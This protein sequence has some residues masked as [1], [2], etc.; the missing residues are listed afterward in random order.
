MK[1]FCL[2]SSQTKTVENN[3]DILQENID[4]IWHELDKIPYKVEN[5]KLVQISVDRREDVDVAEAFIELVIELSAIGLS[6]DYLFSLLIRPL[7]D[8]RGPILVNLVWGD[9]GAS[10]QYL[11][12][13]SSESHVPKYKRATMLL[14]SL[15]EKLYLRPDQV[16]ILLRQSDKD[17]ASLVWVYP[18]LLTLVVFNGQCLCDW[19]GNDRVSALLDLQEP[20]RYNDASGLRTAA[21]R[22]TRSFSEW[23]WLGHALSVVR[24][25]EW[26]NT[27]SGAG[28][29][30][31]AIRK[32]LQ[33]KNEFYTIGFETSYFFDNYFINSEGMFAND[34]SAYRDIGNT[35]MELG[36]SETDIFSFACEVV[37]VFSYFENTEV[38]VR[39]LETSFGLDI[40]RSALR[41]NGNSDQ[42]ALFET[43]FSNGRGI[44]RLS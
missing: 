20:Y 29:S 33:S 40:A 21:R 22:L 5:K 14:R 27:L 8:K 31:L 19:L 3:L 23:R 30:K 1:F 42:Q 2:K 13:I 38:E 43:H 28:L 36:F 24:F 41:L 15:I 9:Q 34:V 6:N 32:L 18:Q 26:I 44:T 35:L 17:G 12:S 7:A 39:R 25:S 37:T 10:C 16:D 11:S 4:R